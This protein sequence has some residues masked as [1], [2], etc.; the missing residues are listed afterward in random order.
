MSVSGLR[1]KSM[2]FLIVEIN[3]N[4]DA[5]QRF[6]NKMRSFC[7]IFQ[8]CVIKL[9]PLNEIVPNNWKSYVMR[10]ASVYMEFFF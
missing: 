10:I 8:N 9:L 6:P 5:K 2:K 7:P 3:V 1:K 4:I